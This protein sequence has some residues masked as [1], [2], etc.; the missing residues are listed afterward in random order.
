MQATSESKE[1]IVARLKQKLNAGAK[2]AAGAGA[3][4]GLESIPK[5]Y[6][7]LSVYPQQAIMQ[8]HQALLEKLDVE[9]NYFTQNQ[10]TSKNTIQLADREYINF[11]GYNYLGLSGHPEVNQFVH[12][13]IEQYGTSAS[14][15]RIVA[16][17]LKIHDELEQA[18][19]DA[20]G[21]EA[22]VIGVGGYIINVSTIA[23]LVGKDDLVIHDELS[24]NSL[25]MGCALSGAH[26][27]SFP[28]NDMAALDKLLSQHRMKYKRTLIITEGVFSMDGDIADV[29]RLIELKEKYKALLMVDEAHSIGTLGKRGLGVVDHFNLD[30]KKIDV[31]MGTMSKAFASCGGFIAGS[32]VLIQ[33]LKYFAPGLI[34]YSAG[35]SP[36]NTA[37]ALASLRLMLK[38]PQRLEKIQANAAHFLNLLKQAGVNTGPSQDS[39]VVPVITGDDEKAL[40]LVQALREG[41]VNVHAMLYPSVPREQVRLRF[42]ISSTHTFA[43]L[44]HTADIIIQHL[45]VEN[46]TQGERK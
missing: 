29:P 8:A 19:A 11:S 1:A 9:N 5:E 34:M 17:N 22:C 42:F 18:Y 7:D 46:L 23:Y 43:E 36:Q 39:P 30:P 20:I 15:S 6:Y 33:Q 40:R 37:A 14:A 25:I 26:R 28:H 45:A 32:E 38:E 27:L 12:E 24:H 41:G 2:P 3:A 16:G 4:K 35:L 21:T 13:T 44:E 10:G 31:I